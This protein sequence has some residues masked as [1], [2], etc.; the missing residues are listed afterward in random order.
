MELQ[1]L[2][3]NI[4]ILKQ[5]ISREIFEE[6]NKKHLLEVNRSIISK[7]EDLLNENEEDLKNLMAMHKKTINK[8]I[9]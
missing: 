5:Q 9:D 2:T 4:N 1:R 6:L 3:N 8:M 7:M